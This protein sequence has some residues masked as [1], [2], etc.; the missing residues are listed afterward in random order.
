MSEETQEIEDIIEDITE[1]QLSTNEEL[2]QDTPE[3]VSEKVEAQE[4]SFDDSIK[5]ILL[6]EKKAVKKEEEDEDEDEVEED[7]DEEEMEESTESESEEVVIEA[8]SKKEMAHG[9]KKEDEK[10]E[11]AHE[12]EDEEEDEEIEEGY[13]SKKKKKE[14]GAHEDEDEEEVEEGAHEDE[15]EEETKEA[16]AKKVSEALD[17][18]L[19][20]E[21]SLT[22]EFKSEAAT[23]F[24][25]T[26][27]ERSIEI[28]ERLEEKYNSDLNEEVETIRESLIERIDDY[29][30]YVVESWMEENTQQ[31]ENTLRTEIAE[32]FMT[33]LKDVFV[34]NYIDVPE[35]KQDLVVELTTVSEETAEKLETAE[36]EIASLQEKVQEFERAA[37]ISELSEDLSETESHKLESILEGVEFGSK[38]SFAKKA[39]VVKDSIFEGK[40]ETKEEEE[41]LEEE[42]SEDTEI[43]IE[44]EEETKKVVPA[45]MKAYVDALSKL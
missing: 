4:A 8:K 18:L 24:E 5:S 6:G 21:S 16:K 23:L 28:Q 40:E 37:V 17:T 29:L 41:T 9:K 14:E 10:E 39:S 3:E 13:H 1:E 45:H 15:E 35:E 26:I 7:E 33:S 11:G 38:E 20:N 30:S 36:S 25:A 34:E 19:Q 12:D 42:S 27:A 2:E 43:I 44:G 22:E 32:N 31:V